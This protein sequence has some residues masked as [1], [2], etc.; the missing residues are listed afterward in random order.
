MCA[1]PDLQ[2]RATPAPPRGIYAFRDGQLHAV[3]EYGDLLD[4]KTVWGFGFGPD[5]LSGDHLGFTAAFD[6]GSSAVYL[7]TIPEPGTA[8][9]LAARLAAIAVQQRA[10]RGR[11]PR[12]RP[13]ATSDRAPE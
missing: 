4:G 6:D 9:L 7:A 3:I 13:R 8:L 12:C 10:A 5:G 1:E 2:T 11:E